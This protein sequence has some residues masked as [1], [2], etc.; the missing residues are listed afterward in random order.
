MGCNHQDLGEKPKTWTTIMFYSNLWCDVSVMWNCPFK[1]GSQRA[2]EL[3][4][5]LGRLDRTV[6]WRGRLTYATLHTLLWSFCWVTP[7]STG[8]KVQRGQPLPPWRKFVLYYTVQLIWSLSRRK[9]HSFI[10]AQVGMWSKRIRQCWNHNQRKVLNK[11]RMRP[12][13]HNEK[14]FKQFRFK[15]LARNISRKAFMIWR[16]FWTCALS[17]K[18]VGQRVGV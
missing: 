4:I 10:A 3:F 8:L 9:T 6:V 17:R 16:Q 13:L 2:R 12:D 14:S 11:N 18:Y 15:S 7:F 1:W 5:Q